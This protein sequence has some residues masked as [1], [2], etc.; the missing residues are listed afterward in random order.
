MA[1]SVQDYATSD[2]IDWQSQFIWIQ[3]TGLLKV[4]SETDDHLTVERSDGAHLQLSVA[5]VEAGFHRIR[6]GAALKPR[7][8]P[9]KAHVLSADQELLQD[10]HLLHLPEG[11]AIL[12]RN[13]S[14]YAVPAP[15]LMRDYEAVSRPSDPRFPETPFPDE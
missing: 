2:A 12:E 11:S 5:E 13:G 8:D 14:Y 15:D 1:L 7:Y 9:C 10:G 4:I 6:D 3:Q